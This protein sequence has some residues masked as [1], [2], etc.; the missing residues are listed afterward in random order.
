MEKMP[1][2]TAMTR[3]GSPTLMSTYAHAL[4]PTDRLT[5]AERKAFGKSDRKASKVLGVT[6][7]RN[8]LGQINQDR[9]LSL[10]LT[11][12]QENAQSDHIP[13]EC[14]VPGAM[15]NASVA[16]IIRPLKHLGRVLA[17]GMRIV[18][19][20]NKGRMDADEYT[21]RVVLGLLWSVGSLE[22]EGKGE[23]PTGISVCS[24]PELDESERCDTAAPLGAEFLRRNDEEGEDNLFGGFPMGL[25]RDIETPLAS[26]GLDRRVEEIQSGGTIGPSDVHVSPV[27][28][29]CY[30]T[31]FE[32]S[33]EGSPVLSSN[34]SFD[35]RLCPA[36]R[37]YLDFLIAQDEAEEQP[38]RRREALRSRNKV[39]DVLGA[40]ARQ[41]VDEQW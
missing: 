39:L 11:Q 19:K 10:S 22:K 20:Q 34:D 28:S 13:E 12:D 23:L 14:M 41:A 24:I 2:T 31:N 6:L 4:S 29:L 33:S 15:R 35:D 5:L 3:C 26:P 37:A 36:E 30:T 27:A 8:H 18:E 17:S 40:E 1:T 7:T 16:T 32:V 25:I 9:R 38:I 21:P